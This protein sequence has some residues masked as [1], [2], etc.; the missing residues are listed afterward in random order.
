MSDTT[1]R[2]SDAALLLA[3]LKGR[4][5]AADRALDA[6]AAAL[7]VL[8]ERH[9]AT[10]K[11]QMYINT[12]AGDIQ[13]AVEESISTLVQRALDGVFDQHQYTFKL[14]FIPRANKT[15]VE[16]VYCT[17]NGDELSPLEDS[18]IGTVDV[19]TTA[20]RLSLWHM[21]SA[22]IRPI[23]MLDEPFKNLSAKYRPRFLELIKQLA[24]D[25][26][27]Q[28]IIP[29]HQTDLIEIAD[30]VITVAKDEGSGRSLVTQYANTQRSD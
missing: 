15:E 9:T 7:H 26:G 27:L 13:S 20:L 14:R 11:A 5:D 22:R 4:K 2:F 6:G 17:A 30:N 16:F 8:E 3:R 12:A 1:Q 23:L 24:Q 25:T 19:V 21:S 18:G 10:T 29:T 28:F